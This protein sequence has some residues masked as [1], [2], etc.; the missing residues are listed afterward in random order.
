M[1][2]DFTKDNIEILIVEDSKTQAVKL[3]YLLEQN[4]YRTSVAENGREGLDVFN[5]KR[6][7]IV[8][9]DVEMPEMDGYQLC[10]QIRSDSK[11]KDIPVILLTSLSSAG[12]I[13]KGLEHGANNFVTKPYKEEFLLSR[14]SHTLVNVELRKHAMSEMGIEIFFAGKKQFITPDRMQILDLLFSSY[15]T[16]IS[17]NDELEQANKEL[18]KAKDRLE[19]QAE[20]L[21]ELSLLDELTGLNNRRG[22]FML[23]KQQ[24]KI[25][26][27]MKRG[28]HLLYFDMDGL[29]EIND[30]RGHQ[31]GD[32]AI[33]ETAAFLR[34]SFRDCDIIARIGGD[35]FVILMTGDSTGS[36]ERILTHLNELIEIHNAKNENQHKLSLSF[37]ITH[38]DT[39]HP[40]SLEEIIEQAD[41]LMYEVKREKKQLRD[42]TD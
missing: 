17:K 26:Q 6:P 12:D 10:K 5:K 1:D 41:K 32:L 21:R 38:Y 36:G 23:A 33:I 16:A 8:I 4:G 40:C 18:K 29:K 27:R 3:Q 24:L 13:I 20:E 19:V 7:S 11:N 9:S 35:E 2:I 14:I 15:E 39:E 42:A 37:G 22:F 34:K 25:E 31:E 30:N 28:L